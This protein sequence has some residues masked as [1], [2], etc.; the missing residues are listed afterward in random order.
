MLER[1]LVQG[2][3]KGFRPSIPVKV[4]LEIVLQQDSKCTTCG[5]R[6]GSLDQIE[7]DHVPALQLRA[8]DDQAN[9]TIPAANDKAYIQAKHG[10]CHAAKTF[11]SKSKLLPK[12]GADVTE[13][14]RTKR[15][16]K[17]EIDFRR[18]LLAKADPE[19]EVVAPTKKRKWPKRPFPNRKK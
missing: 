4:K 6:L 10:D 1:E 13:I 9:D 2:P 15:L 11:G 18:R 19:V 17:A 14:A 5:E 12:R 8:W 7:F 3:P 16:S